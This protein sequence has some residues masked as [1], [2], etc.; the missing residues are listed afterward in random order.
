MMHQMKMTSS[1]TAESSSEGLL[2]VYDVQRSGA[3]QA[4]GLAQSRHLCASNQY[5]V[6]SLPPHSCLPAAGHVFGLRLGALLRHAT[7]SLPTA[8]G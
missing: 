1:T 7:R 6:R 8:S 2:C 4:P 3:H 5:T